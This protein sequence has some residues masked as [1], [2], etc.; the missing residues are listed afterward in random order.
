MHLRVAEWSLKVFERSRVLCRLSVAAGFLLGRQ[1]I[2]SACVVACIPATDVSS[3]QM[4]A[5]IFTVE[6]E[7]ATYRFNDNDQIFTFQWM[8]DQSLFITQENSP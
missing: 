4:K 6:E 5:T 2:T 1:E 8:P 7:E 3:A